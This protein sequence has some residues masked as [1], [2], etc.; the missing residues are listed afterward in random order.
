MGKVMTP[1]EVIEVTMNILNGISVPVQLHEQIAVPIA[2]CVGNLQLVLDAGAKAKAEKEQAE[3]G[4]IVEMSE[5]AEDGQEAG[6]E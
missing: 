4:K 2:G 5:V 1:E 6:A 3:A